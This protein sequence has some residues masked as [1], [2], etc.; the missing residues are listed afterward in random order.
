MTYDI[1]TATIV[2]YLGSLRLVYDGQLGG[3][4]LSHL[5]KSSLG[6]LNP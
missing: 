4:E 1:L 3:I 5:K 6:P 2:A